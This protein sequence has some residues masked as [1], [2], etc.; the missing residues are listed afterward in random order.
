MTDLEPPETH[1]C[2]DHSSRVTQPHDCANCALEKRLTLMQRRL[3]ATEEYI[4]QLEAANET[5]RE[6]VALCERALLGAE[7]REELRKVVEKR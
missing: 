7:G 1:L 3:T 4:E 2:A 5:L 6:R